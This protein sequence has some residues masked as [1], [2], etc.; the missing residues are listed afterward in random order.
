M[1][2]EGERTYKLRYGGVH[3]NHPSN[4]YHDVPDRNEQNVRFDLD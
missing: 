1:V 3:P 2:N 4:E